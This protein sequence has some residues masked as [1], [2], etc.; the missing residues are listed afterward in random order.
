MSTIPAP[1]SADQASDMVIA[2][3][4]YLAAMDPTALAAAAQARC[5]KALEQGDAISIAARARIL[6]AFTA[7]QGYSADADYGAGPSPSTPTAPPPAAPTAPE[8][9]TA[10]ARP[11]AR[12][13]PRLS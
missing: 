13:K 2:G 4:G 8:S 12:G 10:T 6:A 9:S 3:L 11:P 7:G 1:A 5:L